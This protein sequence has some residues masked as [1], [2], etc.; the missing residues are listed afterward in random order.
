MSENTT[1]PVFKL[2]YGNVAV[3]PTILSATRKGGRYVATPDGS[4]ES[5]RNGF[6][7]PGSKLPGMRRND[8]HSV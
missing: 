5:Q 3:V 7:S 4:I 1:K 6:G 8:A 2:R